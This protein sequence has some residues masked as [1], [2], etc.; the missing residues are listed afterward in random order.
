MSCRHGLGRRTTR[1]ES[2]ARLPALGSSSSGALSLSRSLP[3]LLHRIAPS[4]VMATGARVHLTFLTSRASAVDAAASFFLYRCPRRVYTLLP[5]FLY[6]LL[7]L[8]LYRLYI[9]YRYTPIYVCVYSVFFR[10][11]RACVTCRR[12]A[13]RM[14]DDQRRRSLSMMFHF[15]RVYVAA[16]AR[17][18]VKSRDA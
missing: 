10:R 2:R 6:I 13:R 1:L 5:C 17:Y 11:T 15:S 7:C 4:G 14:S 18:V 3:P 12:I 16:A 9:L 8:Y